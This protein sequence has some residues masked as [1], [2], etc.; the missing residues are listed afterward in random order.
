MSDLDRIRRVSPRLQAFC[1]VVIIG[2]LA[3]HVLEWTVPDFA[4]FLDSNRFHDS[5][6][7][8]GPLSPIQLLIGLAVSSGP[9]ALLC[10]AFWHLHGLFGEYAQ[11]AVFSGEAVR[12][13]ARFGWAMAL[14]APAQILTVPVASVAVTIFNPP[15]QGE[16]R[17]WFD[18]Y[19]VVVLLLGG[20]TIVIA[21]VMGE[22][23]RIELDH[24]E[25]V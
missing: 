11:G 16:V 9:T 5:L 19:D 13:L 18:P 3:G 24:R 15:G 22:A 8:A 12:R 7:D 17:L 14:V 21:W 6:A 20:A 25:I 4:H 1:S 10:L 2:F 23:R